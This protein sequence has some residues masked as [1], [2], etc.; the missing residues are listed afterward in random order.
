VEIKLTVDK[1]SY[2]LFIMKSGIAYAAQE[3]NQ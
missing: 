1:S 3:A 2:K